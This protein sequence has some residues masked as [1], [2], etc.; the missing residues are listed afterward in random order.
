MNIEFRDIQEYVGR[1]AP[2]T[3]E[4]LWHALVVVDAMRGGV[5]LD[6]IHWDERTSASDGGRDIVVTYGASPPSWLV[7]VKPS[8]WSIKS[9]KDG[10]KPATLAKEL[11]PKSHPKIQEALRKGDVYVYCVCHLASQT[12]KDNLKTKAE[13]L[14]KTHG[15]RPESVRFYYADHLCDALRRYPGVLQRFCPRHGLNTAYTVERWASQVPHFT[16][17]SKY[18]DIGNRRAMIGEITRHLTERTERNVHHLAGLSGL[19]KTRLVFEACQDQGIKGSVLYFPRPEDARPLIERLGRDDGL[20]AQLVIDE[21][22]LDE[23]IKIRDRL[24]ELWRSV[25]C[26]TIGPARRNDESREGITVLAHPSDDAMVLPILEANAPPTI[27]KPVLTRVASLCAHDIR[28]GLLIVKAILNSTHEGRTPDEFAH[29]LADT[30]VLFERVLDM[31]KTQ[32]GG[33]GDGFRERYRWLT[34]GAQIGIRPPRED[35]IRFVAEQAG[36]E[37]QQVLDAVGTALECGLGEQPAHLFEAVPR[38]MAALLFAHELW[39]RIRSRFQKILVATASDSLRRSIMQRVEQCPERVRKEVAAELADHFRATLGEPSVDAIDDLERV[40]TVCRWAELE[41]ESG[42]AWLSGAINGASVERLRAFQGAGGGWGPSGPRR[43]IVFL[44]EH[45]ACFNQHFDV[46]ED[47]LFRLAIAEN[48]RIANNAEA[49]WAEKFRIYL[50][51]TAVPYPERA[52]LLLERLKRVTPESAELLLKGLESAVTP[53]YSAMAPPDIIG[54]RLVPPEWKPDGLDIYALFIALICPALR[55]LSEWPLELRRKAWF[56]VMGAMNSFYKQD[57]HDELEAFF[58]PLDRADDRRALIATLSDL[59]DRLRHREK[60]TY[61]DLADRLA[62]WSS[63]LAPKALD[64]RVKMLL[65]RPVWALNRAADQD[66]DA[67][68]Q[69]YTDIARELSANADILGSLGSWIETDGREGARALGWALAEVEVSDSFQP[70]IAE[71]LRTAK[72]PDLCCGYLAERRNLNDGKLPDWAT[73]LLDE[74]VTAKTGFV[75]RMTIDTD[76]SAHGFRRVQRCIDADRVTVLPELSLLYGPRWDPILGPTGQ[77]WVLDQLWP[78]S[79]DRSQRD[80][81]SALHLAEMY[82]HALG[83]RPLDPPLLPPIRRLVHDPPNLRQSHAGIYWQ[84]LAIVLAKTEPE[85]V[86]QTALYRGLDY[87]LSQGDGVGEAVAVIKAIADTRPVLALERLISTMNGLKNFLPIKIEAWQGVFAKLPVEVLAP[88]VDQAGI[89]LARRIG[90]FMPDPTVNDDGSPALPPVTA[91][92]L[93]THGR[94]S[95]CYQEFV[96]GRWNGRMRYG[97]ATQ[98]SSDIE[99][100]S[101]AYEHHEITAL[102]HWA[103]HIREQ[104]QRELEREKVDRAEELRW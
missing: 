46:C 8:I 29:V 65:S 61:A 58:E 55:V 92:Y 1:D 18:V 64:E 13:E 16:S 17:N 74:L 57:T 33:L 34:L 86:L 60:P 73:R 54:G 88:A 37:E 12:E 22:S 41:P 96:V 3:W 42:L 43:E 76:P 38:G 70:I 101:S 36:L 11:S 79:T 89:R 56:A 4:S 53:P 15:F 103:K 99:K 87:R 35:E 71:W 95:K 91:W 40:R 30:E 48:E 94:D 32:R 14:A 100:L 66:R 20:S 49:V 50:S 62:K 97:S 84:H 21:V 2:H 26:V 69:P 25:R 47:M 75:A 80:G 23:F 10:L 19:G 44:L 102:R 39:P 81:A 28:F 83:D 67:W 78:D 93:R 24:R 31:F 68:R 98:R 9:G 7:P 5:A 45:L 85:T 90:Q 77:A 6:A 82:R 72:V 51:N 52:S 63:A 59:E 104:H 27:P